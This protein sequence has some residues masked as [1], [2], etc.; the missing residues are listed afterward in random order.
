MSLLRIED[1]SKSEEGRVLVQHVN[2]NIPACIKLGVMGETGSGKSTLLRM[3]AGL[4]QPSSGNIYLDNKRI[5]GP[6]EVLLPGHE[7]IAYLSQHFELRNNY[8]VHELLEMANKMEDEEAAAIFSICKIDHLLQRK[9]NQISGGERQRIALAKLLVGKPTIL[10]LDEP[11]TNLDLF[12]NRIIN[13]VIQDISNKMALTCVL[14]SHDPTEILS[15]AD[16]L[17]VMHHGA[18]VYKGSP[19]QAY[20]QPSS[21]YLA[22]LLGEYNHILPEH[23]LTRKYWDLSDAASSFFIRPE[24]VEISSDPSI[25]I[26]GTVV[27]VNFLGTTHRVIVRTAE[28]DMMVFAS[29]VPAI[30]EIV[31]LGPKKA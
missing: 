12:N 23:Q 28:M 24:Q 9:V 1:V 16:E 3:I 17:V 7:A 25:G 26:P 19:K 15:W 10:L 20:Y 21:E 14:V 11:F 27:G 18:M 29:S 31:N 8:R 5:Q 4:V 2:L 6:D 13:K 30:H 22:G